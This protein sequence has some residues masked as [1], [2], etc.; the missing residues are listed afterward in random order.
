[1]LRD[2]APV[3]PS[4]AFRGSQGIFEVPDHLLGHG[5][6]IPGQLTVDEVLANVQASGAL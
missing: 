1:V 4:L 3:A 6:R 5:S 2:V